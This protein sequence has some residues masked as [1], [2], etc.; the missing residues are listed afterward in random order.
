[1]RSTDSDYSD[2]SILL[3]A[4]CK[5]LVDLYTEKTTKDELDLAPNDVLT[6]AAAALKALKALKACME[7][8]NPELEPKLM[9]DADALMADAY[10]GDAAAAAAFIDDLGD[11]KLLLKSR[12]AEQTRV[13]KRLAGQTHAQKLMASLK[14]PEEFRANPVSE[15]DVKYRFLANTITLLKRRIAVLEMESGS[16]KDSEKGDQD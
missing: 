4:G 14:Q 8:T 7:N 3:P 13:K 1:M 2:R 10:A 6:R 5:E 12:Q 9:A 11:L 16:A 15:D